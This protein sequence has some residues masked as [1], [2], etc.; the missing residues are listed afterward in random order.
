MKVSV[1][2]PV[3][4]ASP[5]AGHLKN[6]SEDCLNP[7]AQQGTEIA[8]EFLDK[9]FEK[10]YSLYNYTLQVPEILKKVKEAEDKRFDAVIIANTADPGLE[11][12]KEI[13]KIPVVGMGQAA[14][15]VASMIGRKFSIVTV[16]KYLI[17]IFEQLAQFYGVKD[18]LTSVRTIEVLPTDFLKDRNKAKKAMLTVSTKILEQDDA[19]TLIVGFSGGAGLAESLQETLRVPVVDPAVASLKYAELLVG[20][21]LTQS[22]RAYPKP[23]KIRWIN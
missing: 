21:R 2:L 16:Q 23:S 22:K 17:P 15:S 18:R 4:R 6:V 5:L 20:M 11:A 7:V 3:S 8:V 12:A 10:I 1:V 13:V 14:M 9:G 19:D